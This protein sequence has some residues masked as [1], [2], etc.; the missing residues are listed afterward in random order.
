VDLND[1][2]QFLL[3][4]VALW[5][6]ICLVIAQVGGW[7]ELARHYR[8]TN[9]FQGERWRFRSARMRLNGHYNNCLT[10]G[11]NI[12]GLYLSTMFLFRVGH[13]P[14]FIPWPDISVTK[15]KTL[16]WSYTEFRFIQT[17]S[18]W[19]RFYGKLQEQVQ[20]TAGSAWPEFRYVAR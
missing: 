7:A 3:F 4:F 6:A 17:P 10:V 5:V 14:L 16:W 2:R 12:Q 9:P 13:P 15:G 19:L 18:V 8:A 11:A 1:P 20:V